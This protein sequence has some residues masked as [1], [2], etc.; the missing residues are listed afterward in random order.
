MAWLLFFR[1]LLVARWTRTVAEES[2]RVR[3]VLACSARDIEPLSLVLLEIVEV[4][5]LLFIKL[6]FRKMPEPML[7]IELRFSS[8]SVLGDVGADVPVLP[9]E[10]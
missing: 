5:L 6:L 4:R 9:G 2:A 10:F 8:W 1:L 7:R 3:P